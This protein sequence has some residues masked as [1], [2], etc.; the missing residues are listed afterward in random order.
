MKSICSYT[1]GMEIGYLDVHRI[2]AAG[3]V[4]MDEVTAKRIFAQMMASKQEELTR[5]VLKS[6][7]RYAHFRAEW[8]LM[9]V[10]E[11]A[12]VDRART[13]AHNSFIDALNILSRNAAASGEAID[14]RRE[15]GEDRRWIGDYGCYVACFLGLQS[16]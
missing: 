12:E 9:S 16:R 1:T 15:L 11:R 6:A 2:T 3:S 13:L 5:Q 14:W 4:A 8:Y 7:I 10:E